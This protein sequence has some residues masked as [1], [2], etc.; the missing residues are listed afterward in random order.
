M[1]ITYLVTITGDTGGGGSLVS[2]GHNQGE[3]LLH[4][5][6]GEEGGQPL[7]IALDYW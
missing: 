4:M 3:S 5:P 1:V 7:F 2:A 6:G